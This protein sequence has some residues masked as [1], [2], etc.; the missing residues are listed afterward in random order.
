MQAVQTY[1]C[2]SADGRSW[3]T[4]HG[5]QVSSDQELGIPVKRVLFL[6][7]ESLSPFKLCNVL[8]F[9]IPGTAMASFDAL[10]EEERWYLALYL[11][12][13]RFPDG[14]QS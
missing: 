3:I 12:S 8:Y 4:K 7:M 6:I 13:L 11:F 5:F 9:C 2:G 10:S 14:R 1:S